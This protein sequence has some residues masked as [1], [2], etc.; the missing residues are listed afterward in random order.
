MERDQTARRNEVHFLPGAGHSAYLV[1]GA[2]PYLCFCAFGRSPVRFT[3]E[4]PASGS[5]SSD[6]WQ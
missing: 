1:V 4:G 2:G 3:M 6:A 5:G